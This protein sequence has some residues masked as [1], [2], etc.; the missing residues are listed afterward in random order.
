MVNRKRLI[1]T[2]LCILI[3]S[4]ILLAQTGGSNS[5][6]SRF[7]LGT[8]NDQSQGF[9]MGMAGVGLGMR[10]GNRLN[11]SNPASYSAID[12][13]TFLL[14]VGMRVSSGHMKNSTSSINVLNTSLDYV[15]CGFRLA[16]RLGLTAGFVP[17]STIG[18]DFSTESKVGSDYTTTQSI[19][20]KSTYAGEGGIHEVFLGIGW[21]AVKDLSIGMNVGYMW[22]KCYHALQ[23]SFTEGGVESSKYS[24]L[25]NV[26][27]T[28]IHTYKI[29]FGAQYPLRIDK[30]NMLTIGAA[31]GIGHTINSDA[32][33]T[34]F[35]T[36]GDSTQVTTP[37]AFSLP[38]SFGAGVAWNHNAKW[39][40]GAD[41]KHERWGDCKAPVMKNQSDGKITYPSQK[42]SYM[43]RTKVAVGAQ[44]IPNLASRG[45]FQHIAYRL[46]AHYSTPYLKINNQD[47]PSEYG[48]T[49]GVGLPISNNIS[50]GTVINASLQWLRRDPKVQG[51]ITEDYFMLNLGVTFSERWF[52]KF[53]IQ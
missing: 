53:K 20:S 19:V 41:V 33:L 23:Q 5:S 24:N 27:E 7:G 43:N 9:N 10:F 4:P 15:N 34:R 28:H 49:A 25:Y 40:V 36:V 32:V 37:N 30:Q 2:I 8:L 35:T 48:V 44:F 29:D 3:S 45:Y 46:G 52:M 38:F 50:K 16:P 14:D 21:R 13:L 12:S 1:S 51:M 42:G 22:G 39:T 18:Y 17:F 31:A 6:Y 47:G 26:Q 11:F